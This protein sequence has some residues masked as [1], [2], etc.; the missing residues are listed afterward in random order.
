MQGGVYG[1]LTIMAPVFRRQANWMIARAANHGRGAMLKSLILST[2][3]LAILALTGAALA[4]ESGR[5]ET[6][7]RGE[8]VRLIEVLTPGEVGRACDVRVTRDAG[9]RVNTPW[10]ANADRN[11]C[12]AMAAELASQLTL[13]GFECGTALSGSIEAS[14]AGAGAPVAA[15]EPQ[16]PAQSVADTPRAGE[17]ALAGLSLDQQAE[18]LGLAG[19]PP[20][21]AAPE[22]TLDAAPLTMAPIADA[23]PQSAPAPKPVR[24]ANAGAGLE[25]IVEPAPSTPVVLTAGARPALTR[26]PRPENNGA[27]RLV[28]AQPSIE[29][30]IDVSTSDA[31]RATPARLAS[32]RALPARSTEDVI[33][34]VIA[35]NA[36][37]WN[38]GNLA[39]FLGGYEQSSDV[40]LV[41]DAEV[42]TGINSVRKHF[43]DVAAGAGKMGRLNFSDL[44]VTMASAEVATVVGRYALNAGPTA[45]TGAMTVVMKQA[46]G[47]WRIVQD[48]RIRDAAIPTLA[49]VN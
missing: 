33:K 38:E 20:P 2:A 27:G 46:E 5:G 45:M 28:G 21:E 35:A 29:D 25:D 7:R 11:F 13:E 34:G 3:T 31:A 42:V 41:T 48:T 17:E 37:A 26:A 43:E 12:R 40:R 15:A 47:R 36:A 14:L 16:A 39:A 8:D 23:A 10:H 9:Q 4:E 24:D 49:P 32:A 1:R 19:A 6:C 30:I 22:A 44:Q 18:Q